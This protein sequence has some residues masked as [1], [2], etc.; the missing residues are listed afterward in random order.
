MR[1]VASAAAV[2]VQTVSNVINGNSG[3]MTPATRKRVESAMRTLGY[4]RNASAASMRSSRTQTLGFL[5]RDENPAYL[6]DP[7]TGLLV[8]GIGEIAREAGYGLLIQAA[9]PS[10]GSQHLIAPIKEGRVDGAFVYLAGPK[11]RRL[12]QIREIQATGIPFVVIDEPLRGKSVMSVRTSE[13]ETSRQ[14]T[15][16]L[17]RAGHKRIAFIAIQLPWPAVEQRALGYH[18]AHKERGIEPDP[19]LQIFEARWQA[20]GGTD[21]AARLLAMRRPPTAIMCGSDLLALGAMR[22]VREAGLRI[23]NDIAVT[24][25]DDFDFAEYVDPPLTTVRVP[26]Y[27]QAGVA[28]QMLLASLRGETVEKMHV[29]LANELVLRRSA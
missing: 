22:A 6:A 13:R 19:S 29:V 17:L 15:D 24:G 5:I 26:A 23:P 16:H 10:D 25:F 21:M 11:R 8:A 20:S 12:K 14:L 3:Q 18:D 2:S 1:D 7:L 28:A 4:V 9:G 27:E